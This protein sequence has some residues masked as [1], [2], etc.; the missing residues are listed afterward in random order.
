[1]KPQLNSRNIKIDAA[2][3]RKDA[4]TLLLKFIIDLLAVLTYAINLISSFN[5]TYKEKN[6]RYS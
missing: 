1:M 3:G 6:E 5:D 4:M 2:D